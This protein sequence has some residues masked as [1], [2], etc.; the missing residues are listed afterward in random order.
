M[1]G[2]NGT[3]EQLETDTAKDTRQEFTS[4]EM[5]DNV[6]S[7]LDKSMQYKDTS[8]S[9]TDPTGTV[10]HAQL[11][12]K[13]EEIQLI[14]QPFLLDLLF[15]RSNQPLLTGVEDGIDINKT[16]TVEDTRSPTSR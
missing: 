6:D 9:R 14:E 7:G 3:E 13:E 15:M 2:K 4:G 1:N 16:D 10:H 11:A 8:P 12:T 5:S